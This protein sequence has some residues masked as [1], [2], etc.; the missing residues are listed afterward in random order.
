MEGLAKNTIPI[1]TV[2][3]KVFS[4]HQESNYESR[5]FLA[6]MLVALF[7]ANEFV[8]EHDDTQMIVLLSDDANGDSVFVEQVQGEPD[9]QFD[10]FSDLLCS[11]ANWKQALHGL[12]AL[13]R[14]R[15]WRAVTA[16]TM[17]DVIL[18]GMDVESFID[19]AAA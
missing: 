16:A 4:L 14:T 5:F 7:E 2:D 18:A 11:V 3:D 9:H 15:T 10:R 6:K 13:A 19:Q 12:R 1:Q 8:I 17:S